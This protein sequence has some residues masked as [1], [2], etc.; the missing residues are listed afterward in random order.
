MELE[1]W[2][3]FVIAASANILSPGPAIVLAI[4][5]GLQIGVAHSTF[6]TLGNVAAIG[7]IGMAVPLGLGALIVE[8]S[9]ALAAMRIVGGCYLIWLGIQSWQ[10]G[11]IVLDLTETVYTEGRSAKP[12]LSVHSWRLFSQAY[13][14]GITNPKMLVLL[15]GSV[16]N[17]LEAM[18]AATRYQLAA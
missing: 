16:D 7:T 14:V 2:A 15:L 10:K 17:H 6:A 5:N 12:L 18:R 11:M 3:A 1:T 4:R 13:F 9:H 8:H